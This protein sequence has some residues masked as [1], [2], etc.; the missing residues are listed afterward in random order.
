MQN[1]IKVEGMHCNHCVSKVEKFVNEVE[2][3]KSV[4]VDLGQKT[5]TVDFQA[6]A[7]L[8]QIKDAILDCGYEIAS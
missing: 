1:T 6:P 7:T 5:V 4:K 3:V 8:E 2:G